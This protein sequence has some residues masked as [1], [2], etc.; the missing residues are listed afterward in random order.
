MLVMPFGGET[1]KVGPKTP[2]AASDSSPALAQG[3]L[4]RHTAW[5]VGYMLSLK[6]SPCWS[7]GCKRSSMQG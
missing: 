4:H 3:S 6:P 7:L 2:Q 1:P 5:C